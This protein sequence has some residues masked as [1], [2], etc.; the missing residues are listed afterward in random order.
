M[1][2]WLK[3]ISISHCKDILKKLYGKINDQLFDLFGVK[4]Y[5]VAL[6]FNKYQQ[7]TRNGSHILST[8]DT[9]RESLYATRKESVAGD[10]SPILIDS[11]S[12]STSR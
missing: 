12:P 9:V 11:I 8:S 3:T 1:C 6:F 10:H 4:Y 7:L 2:F 5:I